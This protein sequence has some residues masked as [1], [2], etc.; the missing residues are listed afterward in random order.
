MKVRV[1]GIDRAESDVPIPVV[2]PG[3]KA[4]VKFNV[5]L[6]QLGVNQVSANIDPDKIEAAITSRTSAI[7]AVHVYG[8]PCDV[9]AIEA[10][11]KRHGLK[12]IYD[13]AHAFGVRYKGR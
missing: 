11:A 13:A 1:N 6:D 12:V 2:R 10:I 8:N 7:L 4:E 9:E 5:L 3:E